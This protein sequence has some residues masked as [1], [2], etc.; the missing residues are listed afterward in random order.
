MAKKEKVA[1]RKK[2]ADKIS[3]QVGKSV[4]VIFLL[5]AIVSV[6]MVR[7]L[8][9][10]EKQTELTLESE[11]AANKLADFF[12]QY[13]RISEQMA[14]NPEIR[15]LL[16][17]AKA[18]DNILEM[19]TFGTVFKN[20]Y[21]IADADSENIMAAWIADLDANVVTQSDNFTSSGDWEITERP[22]YYC[23][24]I[25]ETILTD[26]YVDASTG[27]TILSTVAPVYDENGKV[28][29]VAGLDISLAHIS[30]VMATYQIGNAGYIML[31]SEKGTTIYHPQEELLQVNISE[32]DISQEVKDIVANQQEK[33]LP[34]KVLGTSVYGYA[35]L[36]GDTGYMV[37]SNLPSTEYYKDLI[38][39]IV[40]LTVI[41]AA[42]IVFVIT[43]IK[44][45][46]IRLTAPIVEL[47]ATAQ[48]L[49]AGELD[50]A[51]DVNS[52][53]EI[54]ELGVSIGK[55]VDRLKE[56]IVYIDEI[57]GALAMMA[58]GDLRVELKQEYAGEFRKLKEAIL[59]ISDSMSGVLSGIKDSAD[60]V[61]MGADDLAN[62][63][64]SLAESCSTQ[65]AFVEELVATSTTVAEQVQ[66]NQ[67]DAEASAKETESVN[68]MMEYCQEQMNKMM[69]AMGK[70]SET[71]TQVVG[72]IQTIEEIAKQ[73]NLLS[74]NASIEAARAGE[75]G[76][77]FAVVAGEIGSLAEESSKAANTTR[78]LIGISANEIERGNELAQNVVESLKNAVEAVEKVNTMI[79]GTADKTAIQAE[80]MEQIRVG[81]EEISQSIQDNSATAEESSATSE[82]LAAQ[83]TTLND[84][85]Q[86]FQLNE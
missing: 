35:A 49:A 8:I 62:G 12:D 86:Q 46:T 43:I 3:K 66:E 26:P 25:G 78:N 53:D 67:K 85:V 42:G 74:L 77:G 36:I 17:E 10:S 9:L 56:Y 57:E 18:G 21:N 13:I 84:M 83:A 20:M 11:S 41:F 60:Q 80:S 28:L 29:G 64:Q 34:Y 81:I 44:R 15:M 54:G 58:Q 65:A 23:M 69:Q 38:Q 5:V 24:E 14:V 33:F 50:V 59:N 27:K 4:F 39:I 40:V 52:D 47:N 30:E 79:R 71:S 68:E 75:A 45:G 72:I 22:W 16:T 2:V 1:S 7:S 73:T 70:I 61:A 76:K 48:K 19:P 37:I 55:T 63:S 51:L 82:E 6:V 31:F 32:V